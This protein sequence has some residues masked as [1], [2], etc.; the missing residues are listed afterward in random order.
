MRQKD[1]VQKAILSTIALTGLLLWSMAAPNTLRLLDTLGGDK[2]RRRNQLRSV[3]SRLASRG[4]IRFVDKNGRTYLEIT[5]AGKKILEF[6]REKAAL[7]R[8]VGK[9]WDK[10]WR[11]IIFDIPERYR[12]T[13]D[14]LRWM[15]KSLGFYQLQGSVWVYPYDCEEIATL[16]KADLK[17]GSNVLYTIVERIEYDKRL[18]R[19]FG[20]E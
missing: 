19:H 15:L 20:L 3:A 5:P 6:E 17:V 12:K 16:L 18:L 13:R 2:Y 1:Y 4:L 11:M 14:K 8:R 10:R 9:R 7:A